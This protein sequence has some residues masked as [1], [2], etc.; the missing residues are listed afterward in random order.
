MASRRRRTVA[1]LF[2]PQYRIIWSDAANI[3]KMTAWR[4][5]DDWSYAAALAV[6]PHVSTRSHL[7]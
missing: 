6:D 7:A 1:A 5:V 4:M 2:S 3:I